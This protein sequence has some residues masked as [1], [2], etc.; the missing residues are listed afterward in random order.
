MG[1]NACSWVA[2]VDIAYLYFTSKNICELITIEVPN[3]G[4]DMSEQTV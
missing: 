2:S 1:N 3:I 4:T